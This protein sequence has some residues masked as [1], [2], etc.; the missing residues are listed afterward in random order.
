MH[1]SLNIHQSVLCPLTSDVNEC[2]KVDDNDCDVNATCTNTPGSF[3][4]DCNK[5]F[6]GNGRDCRG[7]LCQNYSLNNSDIN[8]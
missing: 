6:R 5:G 1:V 2:A 8:Y 4:C 3:N 7:S